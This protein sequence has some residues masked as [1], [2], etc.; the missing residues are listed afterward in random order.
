M[1]DFEAGARLDASISGLAS[2]VPQVSARALFYPGQ[3]V[4]L[5]LVVG[6]LAAGF[7]LAP[8]TTLVVLVGGVTLL[9]VLLVSYRFRLFLRSARAHTVVRISDE[10]AFAVPAYR[11]PTY[12]VLVPA[13]REPE[14]I[15]DL[16]DHLTRLEYPPERLQVLLL[17][18]AD[19]ELTVNAIIEADPGSQFELV[20]IPPSQPRT[21]P[22][23][24]NFGLSLA[25]GEL[26]AVYDAEDIPDP[27]QLRRAAIGLTRPGSRVGCLQSKLTYHNPT[28]NMITRWFSIEYAMWFSFFLPGLASV[29]APIPLGGTSN[30]FRRASLRAIGAWDPFNVTEDADLGVRMAR[31]GYE[32]G[33]LESSTQEEAN[34]DF[35][36]WIRQRS[37][38]YKGYLQTF[39][40]H[41]R[42]P[43]EFVRDVGFRSTCHFCLFVG[44]TPALALLS[45]VF[46]FMTGL[47]FF[48]HPSFI[49]KLFPG[50]LYAIG[51]LSFLIGNFLL[52]YL[53][54][55]SSRLVRRSGLLVAALLV[56]V[57]WTMMS[58]AAVK[59]TWQLVM[60]PTH[61][62]KTFHG[63]VPEESPRHELAPPGGVQA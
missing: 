53:T 38:W 37:R 62:E 39:I 18:E 48:A 60:Q 31:E 11:L 4:L 42:S 28:Q 3:R 58:M 50:P 5:A 44:G 15:G 8:W 43:R 10:E 56:P 20:L 23:A 55:I 29:K 46:W 63:L 33:V 1:D 21:K 57:Y 24:L 36:N 61:W 27:L 26:I 51:L 6:A 41:M 14:V 49:E 52:L 47:W 45:P 12:T 25:R 40:V 2:R 30:H 59:A 34:S 54:V 9:Y 32:T 13:Y 16:V 7:V 19:D 22:K 17:V 35:V